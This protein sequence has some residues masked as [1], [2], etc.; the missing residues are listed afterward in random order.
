MVPTVLLTNEDHVCNAACEKLLKALLPFFTTTTRY[1]QMHTWMGS[2]YASRQFNQPVL[3]RHEA[4]DVCDELGRKRMYPT[5]QVSRNV[6]KQLLQLPS[7]SNPPKSVSSIP[8]YS[9]I[10]FISSA[11]LTRIIKYHTHFISYLLIW[12]DLL[13]STLPCQLFI[14]RHVMFHRHQQQDRYLP[15]P[16]IFFLSL[17]NSNPKHSMLYSPWPTNRLTWM[18]QGKRKQGK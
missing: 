11:Q 6:D 7:E 13:Y 16:S 18:Q 1:R 2:L 3:R 9:S 12:S 17:T 15:G 14:S 10:N 4:C 8:R 5:S